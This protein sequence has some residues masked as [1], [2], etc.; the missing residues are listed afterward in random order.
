MSALI[1]KYGDQIDGV[2][3]DSGLQGSGA[4]EAFVAAGYGQGEIPP[5]TCADLNGC[6]KLAIENDIPVIN[7]DYPPAMGAAAVELALQVL[8]GIPCRRSTM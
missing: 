6:L 5:T 1:Q 8:A 4:L 2:W 7:F 3:K